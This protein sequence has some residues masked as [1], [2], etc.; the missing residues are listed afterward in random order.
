MHYR[1]SLRIPRCQ[2][3]GLTASQQY[4]KTSARLTVAGHIKLPLKRSL[5]VKSKRGARTA[6]EP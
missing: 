3:S 5:Q 1:R 2:R 4:M 6:E